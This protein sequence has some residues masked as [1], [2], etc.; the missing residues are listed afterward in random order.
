VGR[1]TERKRLWEERKHYK[2]C[3]NKK[4]KKTY[5]EGVVVVLNVVTG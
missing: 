2:K 3:K 5:K 4:Q 1:K